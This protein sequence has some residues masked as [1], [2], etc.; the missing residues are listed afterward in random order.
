MMVPTVPYHGSWYLESLLGS[1][2]AKGR[3][4]SEIMRDQ[5]GNSS[6]V[7]RNWTGVEFQL[8]ITGDGII[9]YSFQESWV[10]IQ[11]IAVWAELG[12]IPV[13]Q[14]WDKDRSTGSRVANA[15]KIDNA[16]GVIYCLLFPPNS[17]CTQDLGHI[18]LQRFLKIS[19]DLSCLNKENNIL[20][21]SN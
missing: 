1:T 19:A 6:L 10:I 17:V 8:L 12:V 14:I 11:W 21:I 13:P 5:Q 7:Q 4:A 20:L 15:I 3:W 2:A 9:Y 16:T 18:Q